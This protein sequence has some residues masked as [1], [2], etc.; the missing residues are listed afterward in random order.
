MNTGSV[1]WKA[2][3]G[4]ALIIA[5]CVMW[6]LFAGTSWL[7]RWVYPIH[8]RED[9]I[10][11]S[12]NYK[13]DPYLIAAIIR[14]E[15]NYK[16]DTKSS[17]GAV[18]IMQIMPDTANWIIQK[19]DYSKY[20]IHE[21]D[22]R[23]DVNIEVGAWYIR[24]LYDQFD[25]NKIAVIAAYNAG[26]GNV[27]KWLKSGNWDG[28]LEQL[29]AVPFGETRHYVQRVVYY[30]NKYKKIYSEQEAEGL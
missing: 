20:T 17:K 3:I 16:T 12:Q 21:L 24:S 27:K 5:V 25:Y 30:Y 29:D 9:I 11:S 14:V 10:V 6:I 7:D 28:S 23:A 8:Y 19:A 4:A 15:S 18:G 2:G 13:V 22:N 1:V 26:P